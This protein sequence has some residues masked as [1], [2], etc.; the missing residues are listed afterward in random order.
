MATDGWSRVRDRVSAFLARRDTAPGTDLGARLDAS[1]ADLA[2][3]LRAGDGEWADD[4]RGEWRNRFRRHLLDHPEDAAELRALLGDMDPQG[5]REQRVDV[6]NVIH[7][8]TYHGP[9]IQA[10]VIRD[11]HRDGDGEGRR[12]PAS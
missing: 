3:A 4:V 6:H 9:V 5:A 8:G 7:D 12:G 2:Q 10:G 11:I 1:R